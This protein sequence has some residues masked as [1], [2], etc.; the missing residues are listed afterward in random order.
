MAPG[1]STL[2]HS[3]PRI[4][5]PTDAGSDDSTCRWKV[6]STSSSNDRTCA[7]S[8]A[9]DSLVKSGRERRRARSRSRSASAS[10]KPAWPSI[11]WSVA[12]ALAVSSS[13]WSSGCARYTGVSER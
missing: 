4:A 5:G 10:G 1:R 13:S 3:G 7:T 9:S 12:P 8:S 11:R 6:V 2:A